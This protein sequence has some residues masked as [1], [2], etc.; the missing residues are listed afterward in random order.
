M[1]APRLHY[2]KVAHATSIKLTAEALRD[3][4]TIKDVLR[5]ESKTPLIEVSQSTAVRAALRVYARS[6]HQ[7]PG[8]LSQECHR[9][10]A[11]TYAEVNPKKKSKGRK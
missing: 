4:Y 9:A 5:R 2:H 6:L 7:L 1:S 3:L 8:R 10:T 11:N